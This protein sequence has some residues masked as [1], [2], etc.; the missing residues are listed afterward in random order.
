MVGLHSSD[1]ATV[2]LTIRARKPKTSVA[3]IEEALYREKSMA[4]ILGMRRTMWVVPSDFA[5]VVN[6]SSTVAL[7]ERE[8]KRTVDMIESK[9]VTDGSAWV[10]RVAGLTLEAI[11]SRG[12]AVAAELTDDVPEL[13]EKITFYK[14]DGSV[15]SVVGMSTRILFLLAC[16]GKV[17]RGRPRG[18]WISSQY[19]WAATEDWLGAPLTAIDRGKAQ[20]EVVRR[21]LRA[22]GPGTETDIKWWT[23]WTLGQV[24]KAIDAIEAAE[25]SLDDGTG[26]MLSEDVEANVSA[27][28]WVALL[29]SLDPTTM[30]W[31]ERSW[32]LGG[33]GSQLFDRNGNA[34]PT[35]WVDGRIVGGWAQRKTGEVVYELLTDVGRETAGMIDAEVAELQDWLGET[36]VTP[37]FRSPHD[38]ALTS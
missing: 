25:V 31:K 5:A 7:Q 37:R 17:I 16:Q 13:A 24:R 10:D 23:G 38:K 11:R 33:H 29:P 20:A 22:F 1:P 4:R 26:Y 3:E 6:A 21:W 30:G 12:G 2:F 27:E 28:P 34:G 9:G 15:L 19:R 8:R 18:S 32:Y 36:V 35:V 14:K